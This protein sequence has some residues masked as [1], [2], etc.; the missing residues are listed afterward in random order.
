[1]REDSK[2]YTQLIET[3][4]TTDRLG[5]KKLPYTPYLG[6]E[7]LRRYAI[8]VAVIVEGKDGIIDSL[9]PIINDKDT[10]ILE[11]MVFEKNLKD[12]TPS[13]LVETFKRVCNP[14]KDK[15]L[16]KFNELHKDENTDDNLFP[17]DT[18]E[19]SDINFKAIQI[20]LDLYLSKALQK[21][22]CE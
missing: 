10:G 7:A 22:L 1:M 3:F 8:T 16:K 11:L 20:M 15:G 14:M 19:N 13:N 4:F 21:E 2:R 5:N 12:H 18:I 6:L 9:N 17:F